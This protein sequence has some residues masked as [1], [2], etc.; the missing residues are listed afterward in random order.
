MLKNILFVFFFIYLI[1][2][3]GICIYCKLKKRQDKKRIYTKE[4][5]GRNVFVK[6]KSKK[7][8]IHKV[9]QVANGYISWKIR[10]IG[11]VP[12]HTYRKFAL[13]HFFQMDIC[14]DVLLYGGFEIRSPWNICLGKGT[15]IGHNAI[16][17]GRNG[18]IIG[19][20]VNLSTGVWIWTDQHDLQDPDFADNDKGGTVV[21][22]D[23]AWISSRTIILPKIQVGEGA[24]LAAGAVAVKNLDP[25]TVYGGVPAKEI[26]KRNTNL[27]YEFDGDFIP[28]F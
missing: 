7:S 9:K 13:K 8:I 5:F 1:E 26:G 20:N 27:R 28:F 17:D 16:L 6:S 19:K 24:V 22:N 18:I 15:I 4:N 21:I 11:S 25:F 2:K 14:E 10:R 3:I 23:R 12:C